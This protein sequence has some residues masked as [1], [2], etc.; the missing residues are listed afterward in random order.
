MTRYSLPQVWHAQ[1]TAALTDVA[2]SRSWT[3]EFNPTA[4]EDDGLGVAVAV[5][6][7]ASDAV[8]VFRGSH[9][10]GDFNNM[11]LWFEGWFLERLKSQLMAH[12]QEATGEALSAEMQRRAGLS[13][14]SARAAF[15]GATHGLIA[16]QDL[17]ILK[18]GLV[19]TMEVMEQGYWPLTKQIFTALLPTVDAT[20]TLYITGH[21]QGGGRASLVAMWRE[22]K[23]A[24]IIPT[25]TFD[26]VGVQCAVRYALPTAYAADVDVGVGH[27]QI[28]QYAHVLDAYGRMDYQ[29]GGGYHVD[30]SQNVSVIVS[31]NVI[32]LSTCLLSASRRRPAVSVCDPQDRYR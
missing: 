7:S 12:W 25:Y 22:K 21:S 27:A 18:L 16:K 11:F 20:K 15:L 9:S 31:Q 19:N 26:G 29:V 24:E 30:V 1:F 17:N 23:F 28:T 8:V 32:F 14:L 6:Q 4:G 10:A 5:Y 3:E 13:D 2:N